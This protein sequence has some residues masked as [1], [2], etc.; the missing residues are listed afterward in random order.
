MMS[1]SAASNYFEQ[2]L[3]EKPLAFDFAAGTAEEY[4]F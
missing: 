3:Y 4:S 2:G 1:A